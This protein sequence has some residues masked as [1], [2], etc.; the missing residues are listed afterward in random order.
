MLG[1]AFAAKIG[2]FALAVGIVPAT[3]LLDPRRYDAGTR[4]MR[5]SVRLLLIL[6]LIEL[7]FLLLRRV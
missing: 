1:L 7:S 4:E 3:V 5:L 6:V 2:L